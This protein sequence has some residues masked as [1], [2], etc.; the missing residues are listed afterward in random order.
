MFMTKK[1]QLMECF[2]VAIKYH[3]E[4]M[5]VKIK[6]PNKKMEVILFGRDNFDDKRDYYD[7]CYD[8]SLKLKRNNKVK[9]VEFCCSNSL[10]EIELE[11]FND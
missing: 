10:E 11:L 7:R 1:Q 4:F 2:D 3:Q 6:T 5:A 8:E 9:I